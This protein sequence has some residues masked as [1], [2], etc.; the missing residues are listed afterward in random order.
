MTANKKT[1][2]FSYIE[3]IIALALFA[4]VVLAVIPTMSQAG[5]NMT[6][7]VDAYDGHL[8]AQRIMLAVRDALASGTDP[9]TR[10]ASI[11]SN[12]EYSVWVFGRYAQEFHTI[13]TPD[14]SAAVA[15]TNIA[16]ANSTII[17]VV[18]GED[19]Q[20]IGHAVGMV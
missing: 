19:G 17:T 20:V 2:G 5:R 10:V 11:T 3:V 18:W 4:I 12:F 15:G 9:K 8:Q 13:D 16:L 7:A 14:V 1:R 6:F